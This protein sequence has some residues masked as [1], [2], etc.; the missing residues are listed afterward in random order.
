MVNKD[1]ALGCLI[2]EKVPKEKGR[3]YV[4][5]LNLYQNSKL[6]EKGEKGRGDR[7]STY[8]FPRK[9]LDLM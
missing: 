4:Y 3:Y 8:S 9:K 6:R 2:P 7:V 5:F 1:Y